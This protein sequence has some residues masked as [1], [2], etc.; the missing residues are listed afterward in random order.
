MLTIIAWNNLIL[1]YLKVGKILGLG[2]RRFQDF[3]FAL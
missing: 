2:G 1:V 3:G